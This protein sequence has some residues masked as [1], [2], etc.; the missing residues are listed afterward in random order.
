[1]IGFFWVLSIGI[2]QGLQ[3]GIMCGLWFLK[4]KLYWTEK[5]WLNYCEDVTKMANVNLICF[6]R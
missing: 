2:P 1:M 3:L 4:A 6:D 5:I